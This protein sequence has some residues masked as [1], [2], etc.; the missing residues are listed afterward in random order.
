MGL[1][2]PSFGATKIVFLK[3]LIRDEKK[4]L[5]QSQLVHLVIPHYEEISVVNMYEDAMKDSE[6]S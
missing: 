5:K 3:A 4:A 6:L 2:L 1:Y